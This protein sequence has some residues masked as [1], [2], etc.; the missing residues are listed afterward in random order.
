MMV[1]NTPSKPVQN[2]IWILML[3]TIL[4]QDR[5]ITITPRISTKRNED[6]KPTGLIALISLHEGFI[7]SISHMITITTPVLTIDL[8][9]DSFGNSSEIVTAETTRSEN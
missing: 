6:I 5:R 4:F 1:R 3:E 9:F 2:V 8:R 7:Q